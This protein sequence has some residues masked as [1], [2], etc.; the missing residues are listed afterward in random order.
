M[1]LINSAYTTLLFAFETNKNL[2][3]LTQCRSTAYLV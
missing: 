1:V 2:H 3:T